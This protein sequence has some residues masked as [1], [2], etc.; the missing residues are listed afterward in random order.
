VWREQV[1]AKLRHWRDAGLGPNWLVAV[2]GGSDSVGMLRLLHQFAPYLSLRLSV[3]HLDHGVR[4]EFARA[5]SVFVAELAESLG[6]PFDLGVWSPNRSGHFEADAR[7]A[8]YAWLADVARRRNASAVAVGHTRDDQAETILHRIVRGTGLRGLAGMPARRLLGEGPTV[9]VRPVLSVSRAQIRE[10]LT[11]VGQ[12]FREDASNADLSRTRARI[13]NDLLPRLAAEYNPKVAAA[14]VR[15]G[16]LAAASNRGASGFVRAIER[17]AMC[18]A[19][20]DRIVLARGLLAS[21]PPFVRAEVLRM[22]WRSAGFPEAGMSA[23]HWERL[24][25]LVKKRAATF[26]FA[27]GVE[28]TV[29]ADAVS[30]SRNRPALATSDIPVLVEAA[31]LEF[32]GSVPWSAGRVVATLDPHAPRD[33]TV[34]LDAIQPPVCVRAPSLGDRFAPLGMGGLSTP[35][36]DFFRGRRVPRQDRVR[37]PLVCDRVGIVWVVGHRIADRVRLT[38]ATRRPAGLRWEPRSAD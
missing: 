34:D 37:V 12:P 18:S 11:E 27:G 10:Y 15:L 7:Q 1:A 9:L 8:R 5:D 17:L 22:A 21:L 31:P 28:G 25:A 3:A 19:D 13:R 16:A 20:R 24:A 29:E 23:A 36:N 6:L 38:D 2:S 33:E 35:L 14:L 4:G 32:P 26:T 30:L